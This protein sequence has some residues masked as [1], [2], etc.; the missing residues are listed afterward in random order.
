M[1]TLPTIPSAP[2]L[3]ISEIGDDELDDNISSSGSDGSDGDDEFERAPGRKRHRGVGGDNNP[4]PTQQQADEQQQQQ[5]GR[6]YADSLQYSTAGGFDGN[7]S[8]MSQL[9]GSWYFQPSQGGSGQYGNQYGSPYAMGGAGNPALPPH[10][11]YWTQDASRGVS[12]LTH[13]NPNSLGQA[14]GGQM[15]A[16]A[17]AAAAYGSFEGGPPGT[18]R[19]DLSHLLPDDEGF[20][21]Y[22]SRWIMLFYMSLLNLMSDW[23][24]YSVAPIAMLTKKAF[25]DVDPESLV[26]VFLGANAVASAMEPAILGRLGLRK[27]VVFGAMLLMFG[28]IIK[29]GGLRSIMMTQSEEELEEEEEDIT[30]RLYLGF[31]LVGLSQPLYQCT[32]ALLSSSWFPEN[33]RT[34]ATGVAL[35]SN[36]LGIGCAFVFGTILVHTEADII[37]Y[38]GLLSAIA[39]LTFVGAAL[40]FDDAPP[41]PPSDTARVMKGDLE[42]KLP[43]QVRRMLGRQVS[44]G[45]LA[46]LDDDRKMASTPTP[47]EESMEINIHDVH[48]QIPSLALVGAPSPAPTD[49]PVGDSKESSHKKRK[50][51]EGLPS[52][53][54][55]QSQPNHPFHSPGGT[56]AAMPTYPNPYMMPPPNY[57]PYQP[58]PAGMRSSTTAPSFYHGY[59]QQGHYYNALLEET[60]EYDEYDYAAFAGDDEGAEPIMTQLDHQLDIDI[61]DDQL[62]QQF[63]ACFRRKGF[64]H[65]VVAFTTSGIIINTLSTFMD[66]LVTLNGAPRVYVGIV[67][68]TFQVL[69]MCSS[70]VFGGWTDHSRKYYFVVLIML[71]CG[72]FALSVCNVNLDS[73]AGGDLRLN[74][75]IV[76]VFAGPLQPISTE[77]G[78][79]VVYPLS[80]NTVLVIQ[81]L[82]S[83]LLSAAF[84]PI[85]KALRN[86]GTASDE[87][88]TKGMFEV[89]QYTFSFY[90]LIIIHAL[91]T[92]YF[93]TFNGTYLRHE[94]ELEKKAKKEEEKEKLLSD[95]HKKHEAAGYGA[96]EPN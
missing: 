37:P 11:A 13:Q 2:S 14:A 21:V 79:E 17:Y 70:L 31:F 93:A 69:I 20:K 7:A 42:I 76:A 49:E 62:I 55:L 66:Y 90:M 67:G 30:W 32:P 81:Q 45:N 50:S 38:F 58:A 88:E 91:S 18:G 54:P 10:L 92:C 44:H 63:K 78:V 12:D 94:A 53:P 83:N 64:A 75:L 46:G 85:F 39:T 65:C 1:S 23:T 15:A 51:G 8:M 24:C 34:M 35:N 26:T 80:E 71:I 72:A 59:D 60:G 16:A 41:T 5:A 95:L 96:V 61:R 56:P 33:E 28:S 74:L 84:I 73:D 22:S 87:S 43:K 48:K 77:L 36:Q 9:G 47:A 25:G 3:R 57:Y 40:Q 29:S 82:F 6:P 86:V 52:Q 27:T 89:P 4:N 19:P 68:G